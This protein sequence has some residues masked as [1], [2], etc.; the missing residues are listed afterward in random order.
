MN[1]L[2]G[3]GY[4]E[5]YREGNK[6]VAKYIKGLY[7]GLRKAAPSEEGYKLAKKVLL[8]YARRGYIVAP[9]RQ[10]PGLSSRPDLVTLP[11]DKSTWRPIY[12]KAI[13]VEVESC[14]EVETHPEQVAHNWVKESVKDFAEVHTWTWDAC[15]NKLKQIY[16][17][18]NVDKAKVKIFSTKPPVEKPAKRQTAQR[19]P[20]KPLELS[21]KT[22][23]KGS[24]VKHVETVREALQEIEKEKPAETPIV[25]SREKR[26]AS[27][28]GG[29]VE[30][31]LSDGRVVCVQKDL[32]GVLRVFAERGYRVE[33]SKSRIVVYDD[34]GEEVFSSNFL[35]N[36]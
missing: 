7:R 30:F 23:L 15:L 26:E 31:K 29:S 6:K 16:E 2:A 3:R 20:L 8:Y 12:S 25:E 13:A 4:I 11:V 24:I 19:Q 27:C 17:K 21:P 36:K 35:N 14:N 5:V 22:P 1:T 10:D 33:V 18:A 28:S 34:R 9:V 32:A